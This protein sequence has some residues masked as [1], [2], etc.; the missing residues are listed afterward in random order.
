MFGRR[1]TFS[2]GS[3]AVDRARGHGHASDS[4]GVLEP[5]SEGRG[6]AGLGQPQLRSRRSP[7]HPLEPRGTGGR[8]LSRRRRRRRLRTIGAGSVADCDDG[9]PDPAI[10]SP[11]DGTRPAPL[12]RDDAGGPLR[13]A[14]QYL[15]APHRQQLHRRPAH[16]PSTGRSKTILHKGITSGCDGRGVLPGHDRLARPDGH[17]HRQ[18]HRG[19][20]RE[21]P[22]RAVCCAVS[23]TT[24]PPAATRSS[25]TS[26]RPTP[27]AGTCTTSARRTSRWAAAF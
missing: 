13:A 24:A 7:G 1:Q 3:L 9:D 2:A 21:R 22:V 17:L 16:I 11:A 4:N 25:P 26:L 14:S 20:R 10:R 27:S 23:P 5:A 19:R 6:R 15:E 18:G 8:H 12:G